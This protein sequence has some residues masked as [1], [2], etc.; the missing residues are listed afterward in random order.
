MDGDGADEAGMADNLSASQ[1]QAPDELHIHVNKENAEQPDMEFE[2][3]KINREDAIWMRGDL[4]KKIKQFPN[5]N[6]NLFRTSTPFELFE[7]FFIEEILN[8]LILESSK[9]A[10]FKNMPDPKISLKEIKCFL[11]VLILSGYNELPGKKYFWD[12]E[13]DMKN[14]LAAEI[15]RRDNLFVI[16]C[17]LHCA[18]HLN[19][20]KKDKM[21]KLRALVGNLRNKFMK[22]FVPEP[23]LNYILANNLYGVN[24][25]GLVIRCGL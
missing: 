23:E 5:P 15:L 24:P 6:Y 4:E 18:D 9:Y 22:Y 12:T 13:P 7:L 10:L 25:S 16:F 11:I 20:N 14:I 21:S 1:L 17:Y 2:M 19:L 8:F 3:E